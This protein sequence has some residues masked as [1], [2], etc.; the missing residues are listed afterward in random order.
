MGTQLRDIVAAKELS[1][2]ELRHATLVVDSYNLLYQFLTTIRSR[3]GTPLMDSH[4]C[5]TS[6]LVGLFSRV[7]KLMEHDIRLIFVFDGKPPQLKAVER[8]RRRELKHEAAKRYEQAAAE[9]DIQA[10]KKYAA[11]TARITPEILDEA[12]KLIDALGLPLIQAPGEGEAEA[13]YLVKQGDADYCVSQDFDSL[14][15]GAPRLV[16]NLS[17]AGRRKSAGLS[18]VSV[19]PEVIDLAEN[20]AAWGISQEQLIALGMLVGTDF[21]YGVKGV[22]AKTGLKLVKQFGSDFDGLI[23]HVEQ[24]YGCKFEDYI[25]DV[26]HFFLDYPAKDEEIVFRDI[27]EEMVAEILVEKHD[28][29]K[30]RI[31]NTLKDMAEAR[32]RERQ[33][34][35][36]DWVG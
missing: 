17:I 10:M 18:Y 19:N 32:E 26:Y 1:L 12:Q 35:M 28:F 16:R 27:D 4:G 9:E 25:Y 24:K 30:E 3:D 2:E 31:E 7:T 33:K 34:R 22:G 8:E 20:L 15:F 6:H 21:N 14:L 29:S 36:S 5:I 23:R 11:R 13:A